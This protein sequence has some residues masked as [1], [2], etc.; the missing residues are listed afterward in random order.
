ML[1]FLYYCC[2][3]SI[4]VIYLVVFSLYYRGG[5]L[6]TATMLFPTIPSSVAPGDNATFSLIRANL[7]KSGISQAYALTAGPYVPTWQLFDASAERTGSSPPKFDK[8]SF[9]LSVLLRAICQCV[10]WCLC[11]GWQDAEAGPPRKLQRQCCCQRGMEEGDVWEERVSSELRK[12]KLG[13]PS[14]HLNEQANLGDSRCFS[15][16]HILFKMPGEPA[17]AHSQMQKIWDKVFLISP[18]PYMIVGWKSGAHTSKIIK[19]GWLHI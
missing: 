3:I 8:R 10:A 7:H 9:L 14:L 17:W 15:H 12:R 19:S 18:Q 5:S 2:F 16:L 13:L 4:G 11:L 6:G 1:L